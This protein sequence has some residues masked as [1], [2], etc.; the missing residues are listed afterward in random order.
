M[1][2]QVGDI[3]LRHC[4]TFR[5]LYVPYVTNMMY[6]EALVTLLLWVS[7]LIMLLLL[8]WLH[9]YLGLALSPIPRQEN[10]QFLLA[11]KKLESDPICRRQTLKYFLVLP[12]QRI[13]R[14]KIIMEVGRPQM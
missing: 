6:Q 1:I 13:T 9:F 7:P 10:R 5:S 12:F 2:S 3:V 4:L 8:S 14:L 11:V